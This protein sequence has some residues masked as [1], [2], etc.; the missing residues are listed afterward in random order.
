MKNVE[1][2]QM[3]GGL[4]LIPAAGS[5]SFLRL[6]RRV[7]NVTIL[8]GLVLGLLLMMPSFCRAQAGSPPP[9]YK[10]C[11]LDPNGLCSFTG[12]A[13]LAY[14]CQGPAASACPG[15]TFIFRRFQGPAVTCNGA[16]FKDLSEPAGSPATCYVPVNPP[17]SVPVGYVLCA[18]EGASCVLG[19][20]TNV[21]LAFG[22]NGNFVTQRINTDPSSPHYTGWP[23]AN[24][25]FFNHDPAPGVR[26]NC[27][28]AFPD[29]TPYRYIKCA[30]E[31]GQCA[32][33]GSARVAFGING[34]FV[35]GDFNDGTP[36]GAAYFNGADPAPGISKS[37][38]IAA[39]PPG[40]AK[41]SD[42]NAVCSFSGPVAVAFGAAGHFTY[43]TVWNATACSDAVF[44]DPLYGFRKSCYIP[45]GPEGFQFC[46][47]EWQNCHLPAGGTVYYGFNGL[48]TSKTF[49]PQ[50]L[51]VDVPCSNATFGI[52]DSIAAVYG[53]DHWLFSGD[54][55]PGSPKSCFIIP[56]TYQ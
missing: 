10:L 27:Y 40:Y 12:P 7:P 5:T 17:G 37:C 13:E 9:G 11:V 43:S 1:L 36:C 25:A 29:S 35:F 56:W 46:A 52:Y 31:T 44:G 14:A 32:F 28:F 16:S 21:T 34:N 23:C 41:C 18:Q 39:D 47:P 48:F 51:G 26:K 19:S 54:P 24:V 55:A 2:L 22:A 30:D 8:P 33:T 20:S 50:T 4:S 45:A 3:I 6:K 38:Y 15:G 42:E 49:A 53:T